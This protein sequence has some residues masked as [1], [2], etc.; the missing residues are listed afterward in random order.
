MIEKENV[1]PSTGMTVRAAMQRGIRFVA[2]VFVP[3]INNIGP[4]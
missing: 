4:A 3:D 2:R 1:L